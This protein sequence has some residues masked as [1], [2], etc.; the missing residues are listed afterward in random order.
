MQSN[1]QI[2]TKSIFVKFSKYVIKIQ[3]TLLCQTLRT[4]KI[5]ISIF[6]WICTLGCKTNYS[7]AQILRVPKIVLNK[8]FHLQTRG[9]EGGLPSLTF[10]LVDRQGV[11]IKRSNLRRSKQQVESFFVQELESFAKLIENALGAL[12]GQVWL[13]VKLGQVKLEKNPEIMTPQAS[14]GFFD[15]LNNFANQPQVQKMQVFIS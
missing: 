2:L 12:W 11:G 5:D 6:V 8:L 1:C 3:K 4:N 9:P 14:Q 15:P 7:F 13:G 10:Y